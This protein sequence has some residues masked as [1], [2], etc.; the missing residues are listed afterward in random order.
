MEMNVPVEVLDAESGWS[1]PGANLPAVFTP[2]DTLFGQ[3]AMAKKEIESLSEV[4]AKS[5]VISYFFESKRGRYHMSPGEIFIK[6][7][8]I[9]ALDSDF[10]MRAISL[11]DVLKV[12]PAKKRNEWYQ[13]IREF[14]VP[15][16]EEETVRATIIDLLNSRTRFFAEKVDGIFQ[17]L[18]RLHVTNSPE[19]F[20]QRMIVNH[21]I[22]SY[23]LLCHQRIEYLHDLR[24]VI[25]SFMG[26]E[27]IS[28][29]STSDNVRSI[30]PDG[31]WRLLD[32]GALRIKF[33]KV[34]T[35][36][37]QVHPDIAWRLNQ[38]LAFLHPAAIPSTF[39]TK[40]AK[41]FKEF[42]LHSEVIS[43]GVLNDVRRFLE[44]LRYAKD[45][46]SVCLNGGG[47]SHRKELEHVLT[48]AGGVEVSPNQWTFDFQ[49]HEVLKEILRSGLVPDQQAHQF[50]PTP[51]AM[52]QE[53][54]DLAEIGPEDSVLEPSSGT[55]AIGHLLP[56]E[57]TQCVEISGLHCKVAK[58]LGYS[59]HEGDFLQ[60]EP[61]R[62]W[63]RI[64]LNPP[65]SK[66]R[67]E[68][69]LKKAI[70]LM[71]PGGKLTAILPASLKGKVFDTKLE[72]S[73]ST[74]R[75]NEFKD[76][77]VTVVILKLEHLI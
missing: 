40:P 2:L 60:W 42:Q 21:M 38:M 66:G 22:G 18:S 53:A 63:D 32:G 72:H 28:P 56:V 48:M 36:H 31:V 9:K 59:V 47:Y 46:R 24:V 23:G 11:T 33:F 61:G 5:S 76:A 14:K 51:A 67:A 6:E 7:D 20:S 10:W 19:G 65:Y 17:S 29:N 52:A 4:V 71:A 55:M 35:A 27:E 45:H 16:F 25:A 70:S 8:A 3:Y 43:S 49:P 41:P 73:W 74:L 57:R 44:R 12:M 26:R 13:N 1:A 77:S 54:V 39:R 68:E 64:V 75:S 34:G 69:H 15:V 62:T 37:I 50:Y 30:E 58:S